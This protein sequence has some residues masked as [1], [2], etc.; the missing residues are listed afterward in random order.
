MI[1]GLTTYQRLTCPAAKAQTAT[2]LPRVCLR[3]GGKVRLQQRI[4]RTSTLIYST[5]F[6][7]ILLYS[8]IFFTVFESQ[9][10]AP[11]EIALRDEAADQGPFGVRRLV[12]A[13]A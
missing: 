10:I 6:Y 5:I 8:T 13:F 9:R 1:Q 4:L 2:R 3:P 11:G 7:Y 12:A